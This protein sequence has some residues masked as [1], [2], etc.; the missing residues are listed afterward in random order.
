M[1]LRL[2][3]LLLN[4][5]L[6]AVVV[7]TVVCKNALAESTDVYNTE[8]PQWI[9]V[10]LSFQGSKNFNSSHVITDESFEETAIPANW[11]AFAGGRISVSSDVFRSGENSL[12]YTERRYPY[13]SPALNIYPLVQQ[14]GP[15]IYRFSFYV[16]VDKDVRPSTGN[17][18]IRGGSATD[19][20]SFIK[21]QG[22]N[23]FHSLV[24]QRLSQKT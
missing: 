16:Y 13:S 23:Y 9:A 15:G 21:V 19:E 22:T 7:L 8:T 11:E 20:N 17:L 1:K 6:S 14:H 5:V 2:E 10:E 24:S 12:L 4:I 3:K 18:L